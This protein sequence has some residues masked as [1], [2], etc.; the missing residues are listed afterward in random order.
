MGG[1][2][3]SNDHSDLDEERSPSKHL[4]LG[5]FLLCRTKTGITQSADN[6]KFAIQAGAD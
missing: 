1:Q 3:W 4:P 5:L 2:G 6:A